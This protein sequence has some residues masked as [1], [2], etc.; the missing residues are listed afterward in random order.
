MD[1]KLTICACTLGIGIAYILPKGLAAYLRYYFAGSL[2]LS[3]LISCVRVAKVAF[4]PASQDTAYMLIVQLIKYGSLLW[5]FQAFFNIL[6]FKRWQNHTIFKTTEIDSECR[7]IANWG[8]RSSAI[9]NGAL[10]LFYTIGKAKHIQE[11]E[12]FF[13]DSGYPGYFTYLSMLIECTASLLLLLPVP[14]NIK[15]YAAFVLLF[16]M[17]AAVGTHIRNGD[18]LIASYEALIQ[19]IVILILMFWLVRRERSNSCSHNEPYAS[20]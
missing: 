18:P 1:F 3:V 10:F 17:I 20:K 12:S 14:T 7:K 15:K 8:Y 16:E 13:I 4:L 2:L 11:M 9:F 6:I 19:I 5:F